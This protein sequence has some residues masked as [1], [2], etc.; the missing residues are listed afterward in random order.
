MGMLHLVT[1]VPMTLDVSGDAGTVCSAH[2][3]QAIGSHATIHQVWDLWYLIASGDK[4][5]VQVADSCL[6]QMKTADKIM[7]LRHCFSFAVPFHISV[8]RSL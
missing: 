8:W 2:L 1:S 3:Y 5:L 7:E 4:V 6:L